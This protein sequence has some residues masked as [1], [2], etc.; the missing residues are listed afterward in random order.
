MLLCALSL[1]SIF[2]LSASA[3]S[4]NDFTFVYG[5]GADTY[6]IVTKDN[7][8]LRK[9]NTEQD[10][11]IVRLPKGTLV[12]VVKVARNWKLNWWCTVKY[13]DKN[14]NEKTAY[15]YSDN[16]E[17]YG[18][19]V[20]AM[21]KYAVAHYSQ[22][23]LF[24]YWGINQEDLIK[25]AS[26]A[27][28]LKQ[29][30]EIAA[31]LLAAKLE[32][33]VG[34][35]MDVS[36]YPSRVKYSYYDSQGIYRKNWGAFQLTGG[37]TY[38]S[39]LR[40]RETNGYDLMFAGGPGAGHAKYW[41]DRIDCTRGFCKIPSSDLTN[42]MFN[43]VAVDNQGS[44]GKGHVAY[45]ETV[46]NGYVY[47]S[48]GAYGNSFKSQLRKKTIEKFAATFETVIFSSACHMPSA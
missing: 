31:S 47:Y 27:T 23:S 42:G 35:K 20:N 46:S 39:F 33:R 15:L 38:Y 32:P 2:P 30:E 22:T 13:C 4:V 8:P 21:A 48:D 29:V 36:S 26:K 44:S 10:G 37:C 1:T 18:T 7:A 17:K 16:A 9:G 34:Q 24:S 43:G 11:V 5:N 12:K 3:A 41:D 14:G 6:Y 19:S 25:A 28:S 40:W 45:V